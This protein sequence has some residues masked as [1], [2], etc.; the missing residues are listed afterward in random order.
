MPL[1]RWLASVEYAG[2]SLIIMA[3]ADMLVARSVQLPGGR[4]LRN[5]P[6]PNA[7]VLGLPNADDDALASDSSS[8]SGAEDD[9][10][11][12]PAVT[13]DARRKAAARAAETPDERAERLAGMSGW[14]HWRIGLLAYRLGLIKLRLRSLDC[15]KPDTEGG[16]TRRRV[17]AT[18]GSS[19]PG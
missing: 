2:P 13:P 11:Y 8:A 4:P 3:A 7:G 19:F 6:R 5:D 9:E 17:A 15:R 1:V 18:E 10:E 16:S 12:V 14:A